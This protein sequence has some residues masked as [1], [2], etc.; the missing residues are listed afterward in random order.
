MTVEH[1]PRT[2]MTGR[3]KHMSS[4]SIYGDLE[5]PRQQ[6]AFIEWE[7]RAA[8]WLDTHPHDEFNFVLEGSLHV[9][10]GGVEVVAGPGDLVRVPASE[11][12]RYFAPTYARMLAI[13]D[14]NPDGTPSL[15]RGMTPLS[16]ERPD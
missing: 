10:S 11:E 16:G 1:R 3:T 12:G 15:I 5:G 4:R 7:L 2:G 6:P 9:E 13:Y 14:H 8:E